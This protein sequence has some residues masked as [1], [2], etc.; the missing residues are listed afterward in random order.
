[1]DPIAIAKWNRL[2]MHNRIS[3]GNNQTLKALLQKTDPSSWAEE[4]RAQAA[5]I[6]LDKETLTTTKQTSKKKSP[7]KS[8]WRSKKKI[9]SKVRDKSKVKL[10]LDEKNKSNPGYQ[11]K[12]MKTLTRNAISTI[13]KA[14]TTMLH[15]K[16]NYKSKY[17]DLQCRLCGKADETQAHVLANCEKTK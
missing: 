10:L 13:F 9:R 3:N 16:A 2:N 14:R 12:Y 5:K 7:T 11:Q 6:G 15:V 4:N 17:Q 8:K 1:M